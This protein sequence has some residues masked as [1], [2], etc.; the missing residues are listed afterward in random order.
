MWRH[1]INFI[2]ILFWLRRFG[3]YVIHINVGGKTI[4]QSL[5]GLHSTTD[6]THGQM[7]LLKLRLA[8]VL[9]T[10]GGQDLLLLVVV[11]GYGVDALSTVCKHMGALAVVGTRVAQY[12]PNTVFIAINPHQAAFVRGICAVL[13][14]RQLVVDLVAQLLLLVRGTWC[15]GEARTLAQLVGGETSHS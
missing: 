11:L 3:F 15:A 8:I 7:G 12:V 6:T 5:V 14:F 4:Q 10:E 1:H 9:K 13:Y 2:F